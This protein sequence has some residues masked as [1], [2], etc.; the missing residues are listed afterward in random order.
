MFI[1]QRGH[2]RHT[3]THKQAGRQ[4]KELTTNNMWQWQSQIVSTCVCLLPLAPQCRSAASPSSSS[5]AAAMATGQRAAGSRE[6]VRVLR[7]T[8]A[9]LNKLKN[10]KS[11]ASWRSQ[12]LNRAFSRACCPHTAGR[13]RGCG[14]GQGIRQ[15]TRRQQQQ[16]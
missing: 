2:T 5:S 10:F 7:A 15:Y 4:G 12:L 9:T 13:G 1:A 11:S 16:Q 6:R 3:H 8:A 14:R